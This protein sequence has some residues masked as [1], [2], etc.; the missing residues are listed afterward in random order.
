MEKIEHWT[1]ME[2]G[3]IKYN[4]EI[5]D[6]EVLRNM[7]PDRTWSGIIHKGHRLGLYRPIA[8]VLEMKVG[9]LSENEW[10]YIAGF[11]D[12][13]GSLE[14]HKRI[15]R[16]K[17]NKF[18]IYQRISITNTN[19]DVALWLKQRLGDCYYSESIFESGSEIYRIV[20]H[21]LLD[22][23]KILEGILPY[24]V[25]KKQHAKSLLK[26]CNIRLKSRRNIRT[27]KE[28]ELY[29]KLR[30]LNLRG[31]KKWQQLKKQKKDGL[32]VGLME[33]NN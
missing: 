12:G 24:L 2:I 15:S 8:N 16:S 5:I 10:A 21:N 11:I 4:F 19:K 18:G 29:E 13:E 25:V 1:D 14:L 28:Y 32:R 30:L 7:L 22:V 3:V 9:D 17:V 6:K 26:F 33:T 23:K 27:E 31:E 20:I